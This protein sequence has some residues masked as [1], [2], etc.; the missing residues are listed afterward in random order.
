MASGWIRKEKRIAI[1]LRDGMCCAFCGAT[2]EDGAML[3]LD[4]IHPR[5]KGGTTAAGNLITACRSCNSSKQDTPLRQWLGGREDADEV[6][7]RVRRN[8][9]R[10]WTR[11]MDTAREIIASR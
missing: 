7:A 9:R 2:T 3:T 10:S 11:H 6:V 4:H 5:H 8:V 1:Y